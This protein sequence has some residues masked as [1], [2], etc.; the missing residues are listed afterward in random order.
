MPQPGKRRIKIRRDADIH[1]GDTSAGLASQHID[2]GAAGKKIHHHLRRYF[3]GKGAD[4]FQRYAM[5]CRHDDDRFTINV[6][7][8]IRLHSGQ[9]DGN[10]FQPTEAAGR[11]GQTVLPRPGLLCGT[12][13]NRRNRRIIHDIS[14]Y[15]MNFNLNRPLKPSCRQRCGNITAGIYY[16]EGFISG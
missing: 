16:L 13:V 10:F 2:G 5:I 11:L 14:F 12:L 8:W 9:L 15:M 4:P 7:Q 1:N 3:G 6:G